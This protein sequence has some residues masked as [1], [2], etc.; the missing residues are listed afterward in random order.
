MVRR[1]RSF[2]IRTTMVNGYEEAFKA[3]IHRA[4]IGVTVLKHKKSGYSLETHV[5]NQTLVKT[6]SS[7]LYEELR[8]HLRGILPYLKL[9]TTLTVI[10]DE[11]GRIIGIKNIRIPIFI[12]LG[13]LTIN[14]LEVKEEAKPLKIDLFSSR[15]D[16]ASDNIRQ[17]LFEL[18]NEFGPNIRIDEHDY[19]TEKELAEKLGVKRVPSIIINEEGPPLENPD[20]RTLWESIRKLIKPEVIPTMK[21]LQI[22]PILS[23]I[24][25]EARLL[26]KVLPKE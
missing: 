17:L 19:L 23:A 25:K 12:E 10:W 14:E 5:Y 26:S 15:F 2:D 6:L 20:K 1:I 7:I 16:S 18:K 21:S 4:V 24:L 13:E 11:N 3:A 8:E 9:R 22:N